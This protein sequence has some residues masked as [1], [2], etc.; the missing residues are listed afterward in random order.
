MRAKFEIGDRVVYTRDKVSTR[1]G[2]RAKNVFATPHGETYAYQVDKYWR[3]TGFQPDGSLMLRTRRGKQ[4]VVRPDDPRLRRPNLW[5]RMFYGSRFPNQSDSAAEP[6]SGTG[7]GAEP[8]E[9]AS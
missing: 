7:T 2:P 1:P 6:N 8:V 5:E 9:S 3:V 4:H